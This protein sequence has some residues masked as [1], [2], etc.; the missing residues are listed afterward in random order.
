MIFSITS[1]KLSNTLNCA[2]GTDHK[3]TLTAFL[4]GSQTHGYL[5]YSKGVNR[6]RA[7]D[8]QQHTFKARI[9]ISNGNIII[10]LYDIC[11]TPAKVVN[12]F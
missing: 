6:G 7:L 9:D 2:I 12:I 5:F 3:I 11:S 10:A 4:S 8:M 1:R